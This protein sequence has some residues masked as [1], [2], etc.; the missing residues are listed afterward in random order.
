MPAAT[1]HWKIEQGASAEL[2]VSL[3]DSTG[4][5]W[6]TTGLLGRGQVR[7]SPGSAKLVGQLVVEVIDHEAGA[8]RGTCPPSALAGYPFG[9]RRSADDLVICHYD[10]ELYDP[11]D[12]TRVYRVLQGEAR[13]S[14]EVTR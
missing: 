1:Y 5:P 14:L 4:A 6:D 11:D 10:V 8:W 7:P 13:I 3:K 2:L 12:P 9:P